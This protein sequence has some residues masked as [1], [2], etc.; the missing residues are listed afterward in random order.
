MGIS[1]SFARDMEISFGVVALVTLSSVLIFM[2][3]KPDAG[4]EISGA[5][6]EPQ[7]APRLRNRR[8]SKDAISGGGGDRADHRFKRR[9]PRTMRVACEI[10]WSIEKEHR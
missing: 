8:G 6:A 3:L 1:N 2:R 4:S 9:T 10:K 7:A 5:R